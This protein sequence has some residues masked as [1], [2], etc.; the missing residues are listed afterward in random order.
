MIFKSSRNSA[1]LII[2]SHD[3]KPL[4]FSKPNVVG[5][6]LPNT[7]PLCLGCLCIYSSPFS[8]LVVALPLL[9]NLEVSLIPTTCPFFLWFLMWPL[10]YV[11]LWKVCSASFQVVLWVIYIDVGII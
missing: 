3:V 9:N 11:E 7:G 4:W 1:P 6:C 8:V 5:I 2:K 10:L